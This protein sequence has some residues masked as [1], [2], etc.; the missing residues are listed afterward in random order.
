M[1]YVPPPLEFPPPPP[2]EPIVQECVEGYL[3]ARPPLEFLLFRRIPPRGSIWVPI[4]G[5]VDPTDRDFESALRRELVEETGLT[6][7]LGIT[8]LDWDLPFRAPNG[9]AWRLHA[10]AVEVG[11]DF[12]PRLNEEHVASEWVSPA[13][14]DRRLYFSDNRAAARRLVDRFGTPAPNV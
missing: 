4:Q 8:P 9:A 7:P 3:F 1:A 10:F 13:E 12:Q 11:R 5:K 2:D 14:A 6:E